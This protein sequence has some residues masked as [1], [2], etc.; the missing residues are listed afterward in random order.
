M[1]CLCFIKNHF[2]LLLQALPVIVLLLSC[3]SPEGLY[4]QYF[5]L[6]PPPV[7]ADDTLR[8]QLYLQYQSW[9]DTPY[10]QGGL[11]KRGVD[12]SGLV[13][14]IYRDVV[15]KQLP[16]TTENLAMIGREV[17]PASLRPGDLLFFKTGWFSRHVGIYLENSRFLHA[18]TT[19]GV[20]ISS[21]R[22]TY[23]EDAFYMAKR[24][25]IR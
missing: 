14:L 23:W 3:S 25:D 10:R 21:L 11:S 18:S 20:I 9:K 16:R 17:S 2:L 1:H 12:C 6:P 22:E 4:R 5:P 13:A 8:E 7:D 19:R 24:L 15:R